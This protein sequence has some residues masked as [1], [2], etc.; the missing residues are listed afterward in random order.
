VKVLKYKQRFPEREE[1]RA[2]AII[3][4]CDLLESPIRRIA[5]E[6][7][8]GVISTWIDKP[9][10]IIQPWQFGHPD[11]KSTCLWLQSLPLLKPTNVVAPNIKLNR[12][13]KTASVHHDAALRLP[14]DIRWKVRSRTYQGIADA[15]A[16][17]WGGV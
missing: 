14:A 16:E 10:Q 7:P 1:Q 3:F 11:R 5:L 9:D 2:A 17:Q 12:N 13:G 15:M 4:V 6:N 8:I